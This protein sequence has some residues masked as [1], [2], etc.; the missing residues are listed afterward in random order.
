[1][2]DIQTNELLSNLLKGN[3]EALS[4]QDKLTL[5]KNRK[6]VIQ[7]LNIIFSNEVPRL[8]K[9]KKC[10]NPKALFWGF[11]LAGFL[12][13]SEAFPWLQK[14]CHL[15]IEIFDTVLGELFLTEELSYLLADTMSEWSTLKI[16]IENPELDEFIRGACIDALILST[17]KGN[18]SRLEIIHYFKS[19]FYRIFNEELKDNL[20]C[21]RLVSSCSDFWP[22]ECLEEIREAFGLLLVDETELDLDCVLED[23]SKGRE[24]CTENLQKRIKKRCLGETEI[25]DSEEDLSLIGDKWRQ[26]ANQ[27]D[28]ETNQALKELSNKEPERNEPCTCGSGLKY[29]KCCSNK[30]FSAEIPSRISIE[31]STIS[32][33]PLEDSEAMKA[34]P[35]EDKESIL[36]LYYLSE[37]DPEEAIKTTLMYISKYPDIPMLYNFL[38][39][40][41]LHLGCL[42]EAMEIMKKTFQTFPKYL[43]GRIEYALYLLRRGEP[44]K[45]HAALDNAGTL[46]QLY[47]ERTLFHAAEWK[48][49][50]YTMGLYWIYKNDLSQANIYMQII[51]KI[52]PKSR[53]IEDLQKKI[54]NKLFFQSI[55][56]QQEK[57]NQASTE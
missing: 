20:L 25:K 44:E 9:G 18:V 4:D 2:I 39:S 36:A 22:G 12:K 6:E 48:S 57:T 54:R 8:L 38:Y 28:I 30:P 24:Y 27:A 11:K 19:L 51:Q 49:F 3:T 10:L 42:H 33:S 23:F 41:Y 56:R 31:E 15:P 16:E 5:I 47:P 17:V 35:K 37:E 21:T 50:A 46:S 53:E 32:Y 14:L 29:K 13:A 43:F 7:H 55:K 40:A 52:S 34:I 1:M 45:A 26:L